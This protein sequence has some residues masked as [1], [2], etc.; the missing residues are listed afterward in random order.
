MKKF[1]L[2]LFI[3][4]IA[5]SLNAQTPITFNKVK[6]YF[7]DSLTSSGVIKSIE[8]IGSNYYLGIDAYSD[9]LLYTSYV[10]KTDLYGNKIAQSPRFG[11]D[12]TAFFIGTGNGMIVDSDTNILLIGD[13]IW[14][15]WGGF[16]IKLNKNMDTIWTKL[17]RFPDSLVNYAYPNPRHLF[18]AITQT[19]DGNYM[20]MGSYFLDSNYYYTDIRPYL[21]KIDKNGNVLWRKLYP[22]LLT[23]FDIA[24]TSDS[25]FV[26]TA[27][28]NGYW[29][30]FICK[31]DENGDIDWFTKQ[32][33]TRYLTCYD[34][35][36]NNNHIISVVPFEYTGNPDPYLTK[37]GLNITKTNSI[38]GQIIWTKQYFPM[39][40][41]ENPT[42]HQ[43]LE[44]EVDQYDNIIIAATGTAL[45]YDSSAVS[46][47]GFLMKLNSN[48][49][50]LWSHFYDWG[51]FFE[52]HSQ[53][54]DLV[55]TDE[56]G[57][58]AGG[59]YNPPY[60]NYYQGAWLVKT[61]SM[62]NAPVM[63]TVGIENEEL[64][65]KNYELRIYPNPT[66]DNINLSMAEKPKEELHLEVFNISGRLVL[67][68]KL[69]AFEK[70]HR[71]DIQHLQSGVYLV[72]L[73]SENQV[74]Y[75]GKIVK[76]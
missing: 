25:G 62:G 10:V 34:L 49:D 52:H 72:K 56:G 29:G 61:D 47:K 58:L 73:M 36:V 46:Y 26:F 12:T 63:F 33:N 19:L 32:I 7:G 9:S 59:F 2:I 15:Q 41:V 14:G 44:V 17:Y 68:Q 13:Y 69:P 23:A 35:T 67:Q 38:S 28:R 43:H 6:Y 71:I 11:T 57:I 45:N 70:E 24:A 37:F 53:F 54:N 76:E 8:K 65:I 1:S 64:I 22:N 18:K 3:I 27:A 4:G 40:T 51:N 21:I 66:T 60:M 31:T 20:I 30:S 48:G 50:S 74:V 55:L 16:A 75:S 5:I 42:L 39:I